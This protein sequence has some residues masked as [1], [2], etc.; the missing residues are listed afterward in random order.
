MHRYL[1][2][3]LLSCLI[4]SSLSAQQFTGKQ[5]DLDQILSNAKAF[6][7]YVMEGNLDGIVN[8]YTEDGT[9]FPNQ[10]PILKG[11]EELTKY[12]RP[13]EGYATTYH[14]ITPL[15]IKIS[16]REARDYGLYEGRSTDPEGKEYTW[17]GKYLIIWRKVGKEWKMYL[18]IWN[19]SPD[20]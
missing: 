3:L 13:Q 12:W 14:K 5:K 9:I 19:S 10:R 2:F 7:S 20:K 1:F 18:D 17:Q 4:V 11:E 15:E 16:G 8:S 6:S